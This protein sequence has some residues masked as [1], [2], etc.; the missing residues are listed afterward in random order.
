MKTIFS[1]YNFNNGFIVFFTFS[2]SSLLAEEKYS[3]NSGTLTIRIINFDTNEPLSN[4]IFKISPNPFTLNGSLIIQDNNKSVDFNS[5]NG[6]IFLKNVKFASYIINET[7]GPENFVPLLIKNRVTVHETNP[8]A[9]ITIENKDTNLPFKGKGKVSTELNAEALKT[10]ISKG[11]LVNGKKISKVN[12]MPEG[13]IQSIEELK[14]LSQPKEILFG[15]SAPVTSTASQL[16]KSYAIPNYPAPTQE[17]A[18]ESVY[19]PPIFFIKQE[20]SNNNFI[21]TPIIGKIFSN[22]SLLINE[23]FSTETNTTSVK[24]LEMKFAKQATNVGFSFGTSDNIPKILDLPP[25]PIDK[26]ALFLNIDYIYSDKPTRIDFSNPESF[27]SSPLSYISINKSLNT[28]KLKDGCPDVSLYAYN[29]INQQ[30]DTLDKLQ[31]YKLFDT[32]QKCGYIV[33]LQ[34]FSKFAVGG[35]QPSN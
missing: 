5:S 6:I 21:L 12:E 31:R 19:I 16:F 20:N 7:R 26:I 9:I 18:V 4:V 13:F 1:F 30:W 17:I 27:I 8:N 10:F 22:M 14:T 24:K 32:G 23:P 28:A 25:L 35:I 34:H 3:Q 2:S 15:T 11:A 29:E 33:E